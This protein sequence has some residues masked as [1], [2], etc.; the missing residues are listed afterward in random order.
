MQH[1]AVGGDQQYLEEDE[2]VEHV[3]GE[4]GAVQAHQLELEEGVEMT[5]APVPTLGGV[6][7]DHYGQDGGEQQHQRRQAVQH[8]ND[9]ERRRPVPQRVGTNNPVRRQPVQAGSH[10]E[11]GHGGGDPEHALQQD[12][13]ACGRNDEGS[14]Q[15]RQ[16]HGHDD[17]VVHGLLSGVPESP[18]A[19]SRPV[20]RKP[21]SARTT[22]SA[23]IPNEITIA[24][25]T[26]AWGRGSV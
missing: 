12:V 6:D 19:L 11:Q 1:E 5:A 26:S 18:S 2:Q 16:D 14:Y 22:R 17:P 25:S 23:V 10:R 8:Q 24:V 20:S 3:A 15:R 21:R 4:E 9:T 13:V 7:D